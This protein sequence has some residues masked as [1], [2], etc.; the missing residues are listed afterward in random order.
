MGWFDKHKPDATKTPEEQSKADM[1]AL[2][3]RFSAAVDERVKPL[4]ETVEKLQTDWDT[5]KT[6]ATKTPPA[7]TRPRDENGNPRDLTPEEKQRNLNIAL[8][9]QNV[10]NGARFIERDAL[11]SISDDWKHLIPKIRAMFANTPV[12]RKAQSDYAE[13]CENCKKLVIGEEAQKAG[14]RYNRDSGSFFLEDKSTSATR[15]DGVLSD[16]SLA[17][18]QETPNGVR[19]MSAQEQLEKLGIDPAKFAESVKKG[20]V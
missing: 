9:E 17:W 1:D 20:V 11:D 14:L 3:D 6:E 7:D 5:I 4:R 2:V 15:E 12:A 13:Y 18:R 16:P 10:Q 19:V 8:A